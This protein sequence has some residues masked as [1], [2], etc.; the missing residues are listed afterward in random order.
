MVVAM[1]R[2]EIEWEKEQHARLHMDAMGPLRL[3]LTKLRLHNEEVHGAT[4]LADYRM[5]ARGWH[6]SHHPDCVFRSDT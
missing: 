1:N 6:D 5:D 4:M 2:V 3:Y